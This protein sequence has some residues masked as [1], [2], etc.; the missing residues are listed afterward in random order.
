MRA[1]PPSNS[2]SKNFSSKTS[3]K[4]QCLPK[5]TPSKGC[6]WQSNNVGSYLRSCWNVLRLLSTCRQVP[7]Q[8]K[9]NTRCALLKESTTLMRGKAARNFSAVSEWILL[10]KLSSEQPLSAHIGS[11][12]SRIKLLDIVMKMPNGRGLPVAHIVH[13]SAP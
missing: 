9:W 12:D 8:A 4:P 3:Q 10:K 5:H 2:V 7:G 1:N 13:D 11:L 6:Y